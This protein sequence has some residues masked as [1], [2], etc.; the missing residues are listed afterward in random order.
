YVI[1]LIEWHFFSFYN[2]TVSITSESVP[3]KQFLCHIGPFYREQ[4]HCFYDT[5]S[6]YNCKN[7]LGCKPHELLFLTTI[8]KSNKNK[9]TLTHSTSV[10]SKNIRGIGG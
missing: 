3:W 8:I 1:F 10:I 4:G 9:T 5:T 2:A 7:S 6:K